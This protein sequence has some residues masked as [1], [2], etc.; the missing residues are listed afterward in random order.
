MA[1]DAATPRQRNDQKTFGNAYI[2]FI[3]DYV[4]SGA[5]EATGGQ[6]MLFWAYIM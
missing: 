3:F 4:E 1:Q 2:A 5:V 6:K